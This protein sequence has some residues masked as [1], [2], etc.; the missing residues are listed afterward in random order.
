MSKIKE[1]NIMNYEIAVS[2]IVPVY[3]VEKYLSRCIDSI[4][5]Q[6][7][8]NIEI[9]LI[10][11]GSIDESLSICRE[12]E[13]HNDNIMVFHQENMGLTAV[14]RKGLSLAKGEYTIFVDSDDYILEN[15][16]E[17]MYTYCKENNLKL[18]IADYFLIKDNACK[19]IKGFL[20]NE[21]SIKNFYES[22]S[23]GYVW[24][25]MYHN[26]LF[27]RMKVNI[28]VNQAEDICMML[29]LLSTLKDNEVG[30]VSKPFYFYSVR[31][32]SNS[33]SKLFAQNGSIEEYLH[34]ISYILKN[35]NIQYRNYIV[36]YCVQCMYWG[37]TNPDKIEFKADYI[38][39]L[40]KELSSYI[41]GNPLLIKFSKLGND[42]VESIIPA[43]IYFVN[44]SDDINTTLD[45]K[46]INKFK[47]YR[48]QIINI[49]NNVI[50]EYP[51]CVKKAIK[52]GNINFVK[53]FL[54]VK[55]IYL[56]GG[57]FVSSNMKVIKSFGEVRV[58]RAFVGYRNDDEIGMDI[59][60][61]IKN[62]T[63]ITKLYDS[64]FEDSIFNEKEIN[65]TIRSNIILQKYFKLILK[66]KECFLMTNQ[67]K[68]YAS[69][70]LYIRR[71]SK[72]VSYYYNE[73]DELA[74][75]QG[76]VLLD[77]NVFQ[78]IIEAK[79][80]K[81][82]DSDE[83]I[84][85]DQLEKEVLTYKSMYETVLNSTCWKITKPIRL[86]FDFIRKK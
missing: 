35:H 22:I 1:E 31:D 46:F 50:N 29:P 2:V 20:G 65:L 19:I 75:K 25:K 26:S 3:N 30:Y 38:D 76:K 17:E 47:N 69:D 9:I 66:G 18:L 37:I 74:E 73:L 64:Y 51:A 16:C 84:R 44:Y 36:Y 53:D 48:I 61:S 42:L 85:I 24:N 4:L 14:R 86:F 21:F 59:W 56:N 83:F 5:N 77:Y 27:E 7:L 49:N 68:I 41:I 12:Y 10:D 54:A 32:D 72:Y 6:T 40:Q 45:E 43:N 23:P 34:A 8:K 13:Q 52:N 78:N 39:F 60:G 28:N 81:E 33:N 55:E 70:K 58:N 82:K 79:D 67:I 62:D 11:D 63:F 57:I 15:T 80:I 71:N